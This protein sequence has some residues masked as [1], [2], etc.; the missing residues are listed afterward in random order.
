MNE[1]QEDSPKSE[2]VR[3]TSSDHAKTEV[4]NVARLPDSSE[5]AVNSNDE[6]NVPDTP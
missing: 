2:T 3:K 1:E 6:S 5:A 4:L